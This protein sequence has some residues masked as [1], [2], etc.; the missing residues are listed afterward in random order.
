MDVK[1]LA[2]S[3]AVAAAAAK[4]VWSQA[5]IEEVERWRS[6]LVVY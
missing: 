2:P 3:L 4:Y 5:H 1:T 6:C